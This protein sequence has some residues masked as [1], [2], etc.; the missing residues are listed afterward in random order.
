MRQALLSAGI[1][2]FACASAFGQPA[3]SLTFEVASVK[4]SPPVPPG[5]RGVCLG[6]LRGG[7]G[8]P[9]PGQITWTYAALR[10]L[11]MTAYD[12]KTYQVNGPAWLG[13][14]RYDIVVK[15]PAGATK[16]QVNAIW[17]S[18]LTERFGVTL[19]HESKEFQVEELVVAKSGPKLKEVAE[20]PAAQLLP[21]PPKLDAK[22]ALSGPGLVTM[23]A[24]CPIGCEGAADI[25]I[26]RDV[27]E[28][29]SPSGTG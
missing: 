15:V 20:D 7:P 9:D 2:V 1:A 13:S 21:G 17:Q 22:G 6:P 16:A 3:E 4:P 10:G 27:G 26:D 29:P 19:H 24:Q 23:R 12:V 5:G 28:H 11:R 18:V 25:E 14:Q 8:T